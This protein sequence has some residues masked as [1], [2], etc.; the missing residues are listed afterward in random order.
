MK[1]CSVTL[2]GPGAEGIIGDA[3]R[4]VVDAVDVCLIVY[5]GGEE[6]PSAI[7]DV[8]DEAV[9]NTWAFVSVPWADDFATM[10]NE[11]LRFANTS[12][13]PRCDWAIWLDTDE[14]IQFQPDW[15]E[16]LNTSAC[17][18]TAWHVGGEYAK[19]RFLRLPRAGRYIGPTHE[20]FAPKKGRT[21]AET[22][23]VTFD[24]LPRDTASPEWTAKLERDKRL[25]TT[26]VKDHRDEARWRYYLGETHWLLGDKREAI[27]EWNRAVDRTGFDELRAWAGFR[28][29]T[30]WLELGKPVLA[31]G[32]AVIALMEYPHAPELWWVAAAAA[33][34][35]GEYERAICLAMH[36]AAAGTYKGWGRGTNRS[37]FIYPPALYEAPFDILSLSYERLG[38][39]DMA[40]TA[41]KEYS[42]AKAAREAMLPA[43]VDS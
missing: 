4:S 31:R 30:G 16:A 40:L 7:L 43:E 2:A 37:G 21:V 20:Y 13:S 27:D 25:L 5:T 36:C 34:D 41:R 19:E 23:R 6:Y 3:L 38:R 18:V 9:P 26:Y 8:A 29:A 42:A 28:A 15:R 1:V 32:S 14:R 22:H 11:A 24:E 17:A 35:E 12:I 33:F 39:L 10:R